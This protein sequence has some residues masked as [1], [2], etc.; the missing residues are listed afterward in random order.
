MP[1]AGSV[2]LRAEVRC[3]VLGSWCPNLRE[4]FVHFFVRD[5]SSGCKSGRGER[6]LI[7][8]VVHYQ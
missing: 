1:F 2:A 4:K 8:L 7:Q 6:E 3:L 5:A